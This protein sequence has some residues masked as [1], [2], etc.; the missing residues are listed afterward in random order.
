MVP[1]TNEPGSQTRIQQVLGQLMLDY[2]Q[3]VHR[4]RFD[5]MEELVSCILS[6]HS[7]DANSFPA[8]TQLRERFPTWGELAAADTANVAQTIKS[9]G[10][11][12]QKAKSIL[13]SLR[14]IH[15]HCGSYSL[16]F[17]R[18]YDDGK[19]IAWLENL[20]G[21]GPKTAAIVM[22]FAFGRAA[23]PVD[24]HVARVSKR[25]GLIP[26]AMT[27]AVAHRVLREQVPP[28]LAFAF[29][30]ILIQHGRIVCQ[31]KKPACAVCRVAGECSWSLEQGGRG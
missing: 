27:D 26:E 31:A 23:I 15:G 12:N 9:A 17:L 2:G 25:L 22:C 14:I 13:E 7:A 20:P 29:H 24:T 30:T 28:D 8:F 11:A 10:L 3:P 19:A 16:N 1:S 21:V 4:P 5:P 18:S 6:Q